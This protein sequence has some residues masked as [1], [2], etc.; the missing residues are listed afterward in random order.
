G[1]GPPYVLVGASYGGLVVQLLARHHPEETAGVV[2]VDALSPAWDDQLEAIL[3][4]VE[5]AARH[6]I[7][8]VEPITNEE[9]R[10]SD[11][12][13]LQAPPF[14]SVPLVVLR[15]GVPFPAS[16]AD[17]PTQK[18]EAL[19]ASLQEGL[20]HLSPMSAIIL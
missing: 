14:P 5:V 4:P 3:T 1:L 10:T 20:A 13:V 18:V 8:N 17:W 16:D 9:I 12:A 6:A 15:H 2:L 7:P 11:Q 19:W